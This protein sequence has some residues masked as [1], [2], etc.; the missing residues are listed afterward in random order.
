MHRRLLLCVFLLFHVFAIAQTTSFITYGVEQ[1][2]VQSQVQTVVQDNSGNL[3]I[4]TLAGLSRYNGMGF[5][6]FSRKDGLAEDWVTTS[7]KDKKGDI[8]FGH[9]A[10]GVSRYTL[11]YGYFDH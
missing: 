1:G 11:S 6:N 8:W 5:E 2:L 10:G 9:W 3:W 4:G 7:Y